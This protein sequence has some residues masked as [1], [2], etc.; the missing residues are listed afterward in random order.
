MARLILLNMPIGHV[1][2]MSARVREALE[3][4]IYFAVED[5][6]T[7]REYLNKM[8][9]PTAGKHILSLHDQ[10]S[11]AKYER[12][13]EVVWQGNDLYVC[14]E[15]GSPVLSDPAFPLV[16]FAHEKGVDVE[17]Y[18]GISAVT[19]ALELSGLPP[20]PFAFHGFL[21]RE[22][23]RIRQYL[24]NLGQGTHIFFEA[25]GRVRETLEIAIALWPSAEFS[26]VKEIGKTY[27]K[28]VR[29]K[30]SEGMAAFAEVMERGEF[31]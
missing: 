3:V 11:E 31:V 13:L 4:G 24:N 17:T 29:F 26:V 12:L 6:R 16:R 27:Q 5:T 28:V 2:D 18:S 9:I 22:E 19:A 23:G 7:F 8:Q 21:P 14:S 20:I 25:P 30:A 10:S 1:S 15:A